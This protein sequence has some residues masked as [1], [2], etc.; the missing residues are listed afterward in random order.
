MHG[1]TRISNQRIQGSAVLDLVSNWPSASRKLAG[2]LIRSYGMPHEATQT[3]LIWHYNGPWKQTVLHRD[4]VRHNVPH[5]H[6]DI[7]EQTVDAKIPEQKVD[8]IVAFDGSV[9]IDRT[10]GEMTAFCESEHAN[11]L[12][13]NLAHDIAI[14]EK[15]NE[16][17][18]EYLDKFEGPIH[19]SWPN[20]YKESLQFTSRVLP[21]DVDTMITQQP[22]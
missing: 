16:E 11:I 18:R 3:M 7:L 2:E 9:I 5:P 20:P 15:T 17:A 8:D 1:M 19:A 22:D 6:I 13:L 21:S 14:G 12:I 10:R 4:G